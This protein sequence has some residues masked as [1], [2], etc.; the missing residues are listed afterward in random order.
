MKDTFRGF[1]CRPRKRR[2]YVVRYEECES[3]VGLENLLHGKM[4]KTKNVML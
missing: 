2:L 3:K 4:K 1:G